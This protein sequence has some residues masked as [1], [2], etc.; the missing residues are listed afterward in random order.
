M[1]VSGQ[2]HAPAVLP[3]G[4]Q[5]LVSIGYEAGCTYQKNIVRMMESGKI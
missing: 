1:E 4:K 5:P 3:T 2:L